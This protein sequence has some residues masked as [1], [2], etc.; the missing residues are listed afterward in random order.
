[1]TRAT[2]RDRASA[3]L[4][5]IDSHHEGAT[6][7]TGIELDRAYRDLANAM[8]LEFGVLPAERIVWHTNHGA[9]ET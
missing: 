3:A 2:P 8:H 5:V 7:R 9:D 4:A 6:W 1:M